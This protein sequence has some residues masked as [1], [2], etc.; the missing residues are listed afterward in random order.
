MEN[1]KKIIAIEKE[2]DIMTQETWYHILINGVHASDSYTKD[3][4][5]AKERFDNLVKNDGQLKVKT[6]IKVYENK[7]CEV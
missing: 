7:V 5:V 4:S 1:G 3:E 6:I 2:E